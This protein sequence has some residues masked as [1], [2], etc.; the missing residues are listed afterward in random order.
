MAKKTS[1]LSSG[2]KGNITRWLH[3]GM[4]V[5]EISE[6]TGVTRTKIKSLIAKT[7]KKDC[8]ELWSLIIRLVGKCE[9]CGKT[10]DLNA[11]HLLEK[12]AF[13]HLRY[14]LLNGICL[15]SDHHEFN[16]EIS[17]HSNSAAIE[18]FKLWLTE[19]RPLVYTFWNENRTNKFTTDKAISTDK[20]LEIYAELKII[21]EKRLER[22]NSD[23]GKRLN[24]L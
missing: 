10:T 4:V 22:R 24:M 19:N 15:C 5:K 18:E 11:H 12:G 14:V 13:P 7:I 21:Y 3:D 9:I 8:S 6:K 17:A 20:M 23:L 2:E 1:K 16:R